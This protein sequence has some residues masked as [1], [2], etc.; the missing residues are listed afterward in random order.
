MDQ[1]L[2]P[3]CCNTSRASEISHERANYATSD[4][5]I[6][7]RLAAT[8]AASMGLDD[9]IGLVWLGLP[10]ATNISQM[11]TDNPKLAT[12]VQ[13]ALELAYAD[14]QARV[15]RRRSAVEALATALRDR[16]ALDGAAV[17]EILGQYP[18]VISM[19]V[20]V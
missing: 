8:A 17:V 18:S 16:R 2:K 3:L 9:A 11:L 10:D 4:L 5:A 6:A 7:A 12:Q 15:G 1:R 13:A 19:S 20:I 14:A